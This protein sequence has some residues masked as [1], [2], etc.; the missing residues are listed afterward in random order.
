MA[1][2]Q[3]VCDQMTPNDTTPYETLA[4]ERWFYNGSRHDGGTCQRFNFSGCTGNQNNFFTYE[5]CVLACRNGSTYLYNG[6]VHAGLTKRVVT[7]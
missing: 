3:G 5:E 1:Y 7:T 2:E 6:E 4:G